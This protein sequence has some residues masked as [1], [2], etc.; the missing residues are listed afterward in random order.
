MLILFTT[1][2]SVLQ[3]QSS[4]TVTG[5]R[6]VSFTCDQ[7]I[8]SHQPIKESIQGNLSE[9]VDYVPYDHMLDR[10]YFVCYKRLDFFEICK[11]SYPQNDSLLNSWNETL[12]DYCYFFNELTCYENHTGWKCVE[13]EINETVSTVAKELFYEY[14]GFLRRTEGA[15]KWKPDIVKLAAIDTYSHKELCW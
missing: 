3:I 13:D 9:I 7:L 1:L 2:F 4:Q 6:N 15:S 14:I 8:V 10:I 11:E 12:H 5:P